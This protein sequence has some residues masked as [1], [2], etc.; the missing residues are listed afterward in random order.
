MFCVVVQFQSSLYHFHGE[1]SKVK[2]GAL[3][4]VILCCACMVGLTTV[5][6]S[7]PS[8]LFY[9][10]VSYGKS[11]ESKQHCDVTCVWDWLTPQLCDS[12]LFI[13]HSR[14]KLTMLTCSLLM[15]TKKH[16][17]EVDGKMSVV[18]IVLQIFSHKPKKQT[19][20]N[21]LH[22]LRTV[23]NCLYKMTP[24]IHPVVEIFGAKWW[25]NWRTIRLTE[26]AAWLKTNNK[27]FYCW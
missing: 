8:F 13:D 19:N 6:H 21:L 2:P 4:R 10:K 5:V 9:P 26:P 12:A 3:K 14:L 15:N 25:T 16:T 23:L 20:P 11:M 24:W 7:T 22:H 27:Y 1:R 17:A 18:W